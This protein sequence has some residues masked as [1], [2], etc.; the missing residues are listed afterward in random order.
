M[1]T[2]AERIAADGPLATREAVRLAAEL[3]RTIE[4]QHRAGS[5]HGRINPSVIVFKGKLLSSARLL[6]PATAT[7]DATYL[8]PERAG[9]EN[10]SRDDD[11]YGVAALLYFMLTGRAPSL[12]PREPRP[13]SLALFDAG[14]DELDEVLGLSLGRQLTRRHSLRA[15][16]EALEAWLEKEGAITHDLLEWED[17]TKATSG[18]KPKI[19]LSSLPPPPPRSEAGSLG[20]GRAPLIGDDD[21]EERDTLTPRHAVRAARAGA[22]GPPSRQPKIVPPKIAGRSKKSARDAAGTE[23]AAPSQGDGEVRSESGAPRRS[24]GLIV[25]AVVVLAVG[26]AVFVA[27]RPDGSSNSSAGSAASN[28]ASARPGASQT[29]LVASGSVAASSVVS[30]AA[31]SASVSAAVPT[32]PASVVSSAPPSTSASAAPSDESPAQLF[33]CVSSLLPPKTFADADAVDL[34]FVCA[35]DDVIKGATYMRQAIIR[36]GAGNVTPAMR[37][38]ANLASFESTAFAVIRA[39]CCP[40]VSPPAVKITNTCEPSLE[41][42][43]REVVEVRRAPEKTVKKAV[44]KLETACRCVVK[45]NQS[46]RFGGHAAPS[47]GEGTVLKIILGRAAKRGS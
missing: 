14:D 37:E 43:L 28:S 47:G 17:A 41:E 13:Q 8:P 42:V 4:A 33:A 2:L 23:E 31:S 45:S 36:A 12:A 21:E 40:G 34:E 25:G 35:D 1:T 9:A 10:L 6:R 44:A 16:R 30:S 5:F 7:I 22:E 11:A 24:L 3:A 20:A 29:P 39:E 27:T 38:W 15:L 26:A 32:A 18:E 19:D 46:K